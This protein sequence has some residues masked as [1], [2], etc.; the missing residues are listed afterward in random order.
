[1]KKVAMPRTP[2]HKRVGIWL[3]MGILAALVIVF[4]SHNEPEGEPT[5]L[6]RAACLAIFVLLVALIAHSLWQLVLHRKRRPRQG[7]DENCR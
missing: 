3:V 7:S 4:T 6:A 5:A 1:M 2:A